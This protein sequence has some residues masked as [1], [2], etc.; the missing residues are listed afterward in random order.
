[1]FEGV[2]TVVIQDELAIEDEL[3]FAWRSSSQPLS[4]SVLNHQADDNAR[5]LQVCLALDDQSSADK[6]A[7]DP[8]QA[9]E[10]ARLDM[11]MNLLLD[12]MGRLLQQNQ[13]RP[14]PAKI[15]FNARGALWRTAGSSTPV[16]IGE[17]GMLEVYLHHCLSDPLRLSGRVHRVDATSTEVR[18]DKTPEAVAN[19]MDKITFRRHRRKVADVRGHSKR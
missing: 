4:P 11:K 6:K 17:V 14:A 16:K 3:P 18:F 1:M 19:L 7:E 8:A 13:P 15:R 12:M 5:L 9:A 2:D 10:L